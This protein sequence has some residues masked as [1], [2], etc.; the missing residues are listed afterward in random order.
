[1]VKKSRLHGDIWRGPPMAVRSSQV[2]C[3]HEMGANGAHVTLLPRHYKMSIGQFLRSCIGKCDDDSHFSRCL[4]W[5]ELRASGRNQVLLSLSRLATY[6]AAYVGWL[7]K[8]LVASAILCHYSH[9][10]LSRT[11]CLTTLVRSDSS[12]CARKKMSKSG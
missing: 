5:P 1:M 3:S 9:L 11:G 10:M 4:W 7:L 2:R 12:L 6:L 8:N